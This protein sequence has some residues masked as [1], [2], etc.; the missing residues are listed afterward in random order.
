MCD[1]SFLLKRVGIS[2]FENYKSSSQAI[3]LKD[4]NEYSVNTFRL[5]P[6]FAF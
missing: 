6:V 1:I 2:N 4:F 3:N 5:F